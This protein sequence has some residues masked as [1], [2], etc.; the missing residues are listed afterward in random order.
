M[1]VCYIVKSANVDT[2]TKL[3]SNLSNLTKIK[4]TNRESDLT[5]SGEKTSGEKID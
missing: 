3:I 4:M 5:E 2:K 1:K